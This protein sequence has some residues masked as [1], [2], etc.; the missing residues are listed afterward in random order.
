MPL[1]IFSLRAVIDEFKVPVSLS[2]LSLR[3]CFRSSNTDFMA[4]TS[5]ET[6][7]KLP[8]N[9]MSSVPIWLYGYQMARQRMLQ[10]VGMLLFCWQSGFAG[11][12]PEEP[13]EL[14]AIKP[15]SLLTGEQVVRAICLT[16]PK[17]F[18]ECPKLVQKRFSSMLGDGLRGAE[19][20]FESFNDDAAVLP[21]M[22]R[23]P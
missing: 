7:S 8:C 11:N 6:I 2:I 13:E 10:C 1:S 3:F 4:A 16:F 9:A 20:S 17:P 15:S 23:F 18:P 22:P 19:R 5:R 14:S 21:I 12:R